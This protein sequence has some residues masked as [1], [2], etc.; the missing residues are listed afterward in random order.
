MDRTILIVEDEDGIRE[1]LKELLQDN[2]FLV[3]DTD[4][5]TKALQYVDKLNPE[6]V[7]LDLKLPDIK[8][9]DVCRKIKDIYPEIKIIML[10]AKD[11]P[12]ELKEGLEIGADDYV[13]KPFEEKE[14]LARIRARLRS[15]ENEN[16][17]LKVHDLTLNQKTF[18]V[19]RGGKIITLTLQEFRLLEYMVINKNQVLSRE[20]ILNKIWQYSPEV[21]SRVVDVYVGYLRKKIDKGNPRKIIHSVRGF[22]YIVK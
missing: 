19:A 22:G 13:K 15:S 14:L 3:K 11:S 17:L 5:G 4:S 12:D 8:G 6:L 20:R 9:E 10:T 2:G 16:K 1:Y 18:E 21:E 7:L